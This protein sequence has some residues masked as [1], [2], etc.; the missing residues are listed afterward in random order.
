[1]FAMLIL[2]VVLLAAGAVVA[3]VRGLLAFSR[4]GDRIKGNDDAYLRRGE[5]QNRMMT[6]RVM[7]QAA[8]ILAVTVLG[9]L[10]S[11]R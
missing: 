4:E 5:Q 3:L 7:F 10:F 11:S 8:A 2:L 6:L 9:L 1:M